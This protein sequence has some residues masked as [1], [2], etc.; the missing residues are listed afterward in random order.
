MRDKCFDSLINK[1]NTEIVC[2]S[3]WFKINKLSLNIKKKH[4]MLFC[5]KRIRKV[6]PSDKI[7]I[8]NILVEQVAETKFPGVIITENLTWDNHIK[9]ICNKVSKGIGIIYKIHHLIPPSILID[10]YFTLVHPYFQYCNIVWASNSS[11]SLSKLSKM[12]KR[13][14]RVITNSKWNAQTAPIFIIFVCSLYAI[15]IRFKLDVSCLRLIIVS[16]PLNSIGMFLQNMN[17][18]NH[19]TRNKLG[20]HVISH[21]LTVREFSITIYGVKLGNNLPAF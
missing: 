17:I 4:F 15:S 12:Q 3:K 9:T 2:I 21:S 1:I 11:L 8:N 7:Y 16:L 20:F 14:M 19:N 6:K 10:L 18:H 13:A 5:N